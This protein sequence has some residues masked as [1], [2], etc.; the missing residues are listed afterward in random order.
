MSEVA[1]RED[2]THVHQMLSRLS[3][4]ASLES[5]EQSAREIQLSIMEQILSAET[6]E[7]VYAAQE[8]GTTGTKDFV[9]IPFRVRE[10]DIAWR[11]SGVEGG[12][13]P[14][15]AVLNA[16][17]LDT[18]EAITLSGGGITFVAALDRLL[19]LDTFR[20]HEEDGGK[21]LII[22][23]K[24]TGKGYEVL[25]L[26]SFNLAPAKSKAKTDGKAGA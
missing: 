16:T 1:I 18:G 7:D 14:Y 4:E 23:S 10:A 24:T 2:Y 19:S 6:E 21:P 17:R 11:R 9:G 22:T 25:M 3:I 26:K 15:Y 13:F 12:G 8:A 20:A 5:N